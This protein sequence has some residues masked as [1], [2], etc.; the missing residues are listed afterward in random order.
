MSQAGVILIVVSSSAAG[1]VAG[2]HSGR[3]CHQVIASELL[4]CRWAKGATY[5]HILEAA[6]I[7]VE[8]CP[9]VVARATR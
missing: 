3:L 5:G 2:W 9:S 6:A 4:G 7:L 1:S 8:D